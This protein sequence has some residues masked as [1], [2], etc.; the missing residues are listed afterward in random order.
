MVSTLGK[1]ATLPLEV[2]VGQEVEKVTWSSPGLVAILQ[3]GPAGKP[4]LVA[5]TQGPK[6]RRVNV[7]R[8]DYSF[9]ISSLRLQ[10][11][12][13]YRAWITLQSPLINMTKDFTLRVY[14]GG[15]GG[16]GPTFEL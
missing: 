15:G 5:G 8:H 10:D 4:V 9:Q 2:P 3:P 14:G 11:S 13:S 16:R 1:S 6:S 12:G 7:L